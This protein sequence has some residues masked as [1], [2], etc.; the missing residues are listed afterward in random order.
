[1]HQEAI[2]E[3]AAHAMH[4]EADFNGGSS[5]ELQSLSKELGS[6]KPDKE[7]K[8]EETNEMVWHP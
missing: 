8:S 4:L 6:Q 3:S 7:A 2:A 5:A 1:M